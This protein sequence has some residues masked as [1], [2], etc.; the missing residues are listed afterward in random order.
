MLIAPDVSHYLT[1]MPIG[2]P[3]GRQLAPAMQ[4]PSM[5]LTATF[6]TDPNDG[7]RTDRFTGGAVVFMTTTAFFGRTAALTR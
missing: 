7:L 5:A 4:K 6:R 2:T 3:D 1:A